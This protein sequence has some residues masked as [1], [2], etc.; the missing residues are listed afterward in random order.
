MEEKN[1]A[2][3]TQRHYVRGLRVFLKFCQEQGWNKI[4]LTKIV[5]PKKITKEVIYLENG[6]IKQVAET[7]KNM[8]FRAIFELFLSTGLRLKEPTSLNRNDIQNGEIKIIGKGNKERIVFVTKRAKK[9]LNKYL[10]TRKDDNPALF[11]SE[12]NQR[13]VPGTVENFFW[14][15]NKKVNLGKNFSCH[16]FRHSFATA[17]VN[18]G[19]D[20][21]FVQKLLGHTDIKTTAQYYLGTSKEKLKEVHQKFLKYD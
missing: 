8:K 10:E 7:I 4:D 20:I 12:L 15:L 16:T 9:W 2:Q 6:E 11:L 17:L 3:M 19:A 18:N 14:H 21:S 5:L 1:L 13:I